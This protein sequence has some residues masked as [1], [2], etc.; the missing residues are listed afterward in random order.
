MIRRLSPARH[1]GTAGTA[2]TA[3]TATTAATAGLAVLA[4]LL[5]VLAAAFAPAPALAQDF[6]LADFKL[7]NGLRV[8]LQP[9]DAVPSICLGIAFHAGSKNERPGITGISHLFE[10]MMFNGST[11]YPPKE[12]DRILEGGGG[13]SNAFTSDDMTLYHEEFNPELLPTVLA[14]EADRMRALK[15]DAENVE[16]ERGIVQEERRLRVDDSP[17]SR[18]YE[19]LRAVAFD[20]HP[21]GIPTIG[22]MKDLERITVADCRDYFRTY[23]APNNA[24]LCLTGAFDPQAARPL[25]EKAF[26]D[27][28]A[29]APPTPVVESE[30]PQLGE[31]RLEVELPAEQP[32]VL[33]AY[34]MVGRTHPDYL[35]YD[36]L[37]NILGL[38]ESS[39]LHQALVYDAQVASDAECF[40]DGSEH[41]GLFYLWVDVTP[42]KTPAEAVAAIDSVVARLV[43]AGVTPDE[44]EKAR[45][46]AQGAVVRGLTTNSSRTEHLLTYQVLNG[47]YRKL[48]S[49]VA[50]YDRV[51]AEDVTRVARES[52]VPRNRTIGILVPARDRM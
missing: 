12:F 40:L 1:A 22:W 49:I 20:A 33:A 4:S 42:G 45:S 3:G 27:I 23:Y 8:I 26:G 17:R 52:L 37:T 19:E 50:D 10:H 11:L 28:R 43:T 41:P 15:I 21:Y 39:R 47:D 18:L 16:Q 2:A 7:E 6:P 25:I 29:Q 51:T 14:M 36:L 9:N 24:V 31:R 5:L 34:H 38:G 35:A 46:Q 44:V 32:A 48:L 13:Y 30:D